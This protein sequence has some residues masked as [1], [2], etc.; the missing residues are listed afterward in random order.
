MRQQICLFFFLFKRELEQQDKFVIMSINYVVG[1]IL[2]IIN[3]YITTYSAPTPLG[4]AEA[5]LLKAADVDL[6][7][8]EC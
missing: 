2:I 5:G 4:R 6:L 7:D 3:M 1:V 8:V